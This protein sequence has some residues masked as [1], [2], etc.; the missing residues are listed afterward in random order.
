MKQRKEEERR[1]RKRNDRRVAGGETEQKRDFNEI[2][3]HMKSW[4]QLNMFVLI[5][6]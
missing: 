2:T 4:L 5:T 3:P 1:G 6:D